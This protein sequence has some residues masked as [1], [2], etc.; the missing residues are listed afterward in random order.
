MPPI[1]K[2]RTVRV[3]WDDAFSEDP[4][5]EVENIKKNKELHT[6]TT[7]G[8]LVDQDDTHYYVASTWSSGEVACTMGIPKGMV[9]VFEEVVVTKRKKKVV[10]QEGLEPSTP[11]LQGG[12][13]TN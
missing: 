11:R 3:V 12:C 7:I 13:S 6:C 4:W 9:K 1:K 2:L 10:P 8:F 5:T